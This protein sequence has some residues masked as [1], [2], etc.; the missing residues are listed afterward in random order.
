MRGC[1]RAPLTLIP[2]QRATL[3]TST[4][5]DRKRRRAI[6]SGKT[7]EIIMRT[8]A[9]GGW[10]RIERPLPEKGDLRG[11]FTEGE[12][13]DS[14]SPRPAPTEDAEAAAAAAAAK[15]KDK[16]VMCFST[17]PVETFEV[18]NDLVVDRGPSPYV[19]LLEVFGE[20][21]W[22]VRGWFNTLTL[23]A[24]RRRTPHDYCS[25]RRTLHLDTNWLHCLLAVCWRLTCSPRDSSHS[26]QPNLPSHAIVQADAVARQ[27]GAPHCCSLQ[28]PQHSLG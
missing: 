16:E 5:A 21:V 7:G 15:R 19:S 9:D 23:H 2:P 13:T 12:G 24:T 20:W 27:H 11:H 10:D 22:L 6:K 1:M 8:I 28:L 26:H 25:S 3:P 18:L 14:M 4:D 17:R